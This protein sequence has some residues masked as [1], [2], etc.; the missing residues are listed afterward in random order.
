M[1]RFLYLFIIIAVI[2]LVVLVGYFLRERAN[3]GETGGA[4]GAL[5]SAPPQRFPTSTSGAQ[6]PSAAG[7]PGG[8]LPQTTFLGQKFGVVA[9]N[10]VMSFFVDGQNIA[11]LVQPD[12]QIVRVVNGEVSVLSSSAITN[13][14]E[15]SFSYDGKRI[16]AVFGDQSSPQASIF[17]ILN[18]SWQ[19]LSPGLKSPA[20]SPDDYQIVYLTS[21]GGAAALTTLDT[22]NPKAKPQ[23]LAKFHLQDVSLNWPTRNKII[24]SDRGSAFFAGSIWSF[25][26]KTKTP[27]ELTDSKPGLESVWSSKWEFGLALEADFNGLGG[28][29]SLIDGTGKTL[30]DLAFLT[31]PSKCA[32]DI[33]IQQPQT[34]PTKATTSTAKNATSTKT[35]TSTV[36]AAPPAKKFLYCAVPQDQNKLAASQLPDDYEKRAMFTTDD[37]FRINL[38]LGA[39]EAGNIE[40]V[41]SGSGQNLDASNLKIF[42]QT[43]FFINRLDQKLYAVSLK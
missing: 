20:W 18:K 24:I 11:V 4:T 25:D 7:Q 31:L 32:F 10:K 15:A 30:N 23:E 16:L 12:G 29:L 14:R 3:V 38:N 41:F 37:F 5:P 35:P 40:P 39:P 17:D 1:R 43:I 34:T 42:N 6:P 13:L 19:P 36:P 9:Q 27:T 22:A 2:A 26:A 21:K 28:K 8:T 33:Q